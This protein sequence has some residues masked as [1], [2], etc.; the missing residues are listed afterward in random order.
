MDIYELLNKIVEQG[1]VESILGKDNIKE[2]L[3]TECN[4]KLF[5]ICEKILL[6]ETN[7]MIDDIEDLT[8]DD[9]E[10]LNSIELDKVP[11]VLKARISDVLWKQKRNYQ[12]A[13]NAIKAYLDLFN[14]P[15]SDNNKDEALNFI[16]RA[17]SISKQI[18]E[19]EL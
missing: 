18:N 5:E 16:K 6:L 14:V 8:E 19:K 12:A 17:I 11:L 2:K 13:K 4:K 15:I 3:D 7:G 10:S 1:N 9:I